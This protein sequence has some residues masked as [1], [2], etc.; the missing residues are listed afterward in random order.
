M[1]DRELQLLLKKWLKEWMSQQVDDLKTSKDQNNQSFAFL[2]DRTLQMLLM[3]FM[4]NKNQT[5]EGD[6]KMSSSES[7]EDWEQV[8]KETEQGF[9]Q[10]LDLLE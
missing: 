6:N 10:I 8:M 3:M 4:M 2:D 9:K 1:N 7:S 5:Q